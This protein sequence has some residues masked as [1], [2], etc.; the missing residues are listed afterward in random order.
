M[1]KIK[2]WLK[3]KLLGRQSEVTINPPRARLPRNK[4]GVSTD[5]YEVESTFTSNVRGKIVSIGP[6]KNILVSAYS[7]EYE[8]TVPNLEIIE[9]EGPNGGPVSGFDPYDSAVLLK[10]DLFKSKRKSTE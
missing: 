3:A 4:V 6:G 8:E 7:D 1:K 10:A 5:E 9:E 2:I